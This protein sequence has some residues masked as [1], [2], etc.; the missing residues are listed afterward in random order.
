MNETTHE[1]IKVPEEEWATYCSTGTN[2]DNLECEAGY[3][4]AFT[5]DE[6]ER[7]VFVLRV[8]IW[9]CCCGK[10][11]AGA[12]DFLVFD[13]FWVSRVGILLP[14]HLAQA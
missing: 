11:N 2:K 3:Y 12:E 13:I 1:L 9:R 8:E 5:G 6:A 4:L 10:E 7:L 14:A